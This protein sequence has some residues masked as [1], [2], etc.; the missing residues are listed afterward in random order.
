MVAT[1]VADWLTAIGTV[2]AVVVALATPAVISI[3]R[4]RR[5]PVLRI[6]L[7]GSEPDL[8]AVLDASSDAIVAFWLRFTVTNSGRSTAQAV[9]AQLRRYWVR[10]AAKDDHDAP[11][12]E[13]AI[14]P[15]PL[16]WIS[17]P[18]HV[19]AARREAVAIPAGASDLATVALFT[20]HDAMM[21]LKFLDA[22]YVPPSPPTASLIEYRFQVSVGADNADLID[23]HLWCERDPASGLLTG[24]GQGRKAPL[25][26]RTHLMV[27]RAGNPP[28]TPNGSAV[29][30]AGDN[31]EPQSG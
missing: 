15:Q 22:D 8:R 1:S 23:S 7:S 19:D 28:P 2:G 25:A 18:Y 16:S 5:R 12:V 29:S 10:Q 21:T 24:A 26:A 27:P 3:L 6:E 4:R 9:R 11:W 13:C 30:T 14:D 17:R 20:V 31:S